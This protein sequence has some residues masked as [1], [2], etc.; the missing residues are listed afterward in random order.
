MLRKIRIIVA[1]FFILSIS[2]LFLD[3]TGTAQKYL[4]WTAKVQLVP[5]ILAAN[6]AVLAGIFV[7]TLFFGRIYCSA[8]CPLGIFQDVI[9]RITALIK[10][11]RFSY[12]APKKLLVILRFMILAAFI[13]AFWAN[14]AVIKVLLEPFSIFGRIVSQV[15]TP[16]HGFTNVFWVAISSFVI[17]VIFAIKSG[18]GYC[19]TICPVGT[20]LAV[21]TKLS[22]ISSPIDRKKCN[23]CGVCV[24][25]C[26]AE[27]IDTANKKIDYLRCVSCCNCIVECP[28]RAIKLSWKTDKA[29]LVPTPKSDEF[30]TNDGIS[31]RRFVSATAFLTLGLI[32][33]VKG[34]ANLMLLDDKIAQ[35]RSLPIVPPGAGSLQNFRRRCTGCQLCVSACPNNLLSPSN[36]LSDFL[37]PYLSFEQGWCRPECVKCSQVCSTGA[38]RTITAEEKASTQIGIAVWKSDL[39]LITKHGTRCDLCSRK[40]PTGAIT[41]VNQTANDPKSPKIPTIDSARCIGCGACE[42]YC[43]SRPYSAISINGVETHRKI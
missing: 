29:Q 24:K 5:A 13:A 42:W 36:N 32:S 8:F 18:R 11:N 10:K 16:F 15:S 34:T 37:Q 7:L 38:I 2:L 39:C 14:I 30:L 21:I 6:F 35:A 31:R 41:M 3:Y 23:S 33:R 26:K 4:T 9:S 20:L 25:N 1:V 12:K 28:E 19:N 17:I 40:C 22:F 27:C 43:L